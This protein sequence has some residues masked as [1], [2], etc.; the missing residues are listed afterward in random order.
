MAG[1][2]DEGSP[3]TVGRL[4][5]L[6]SGYCF[7]AVACLAVGLGVSGFTDFRN[8]ANLAVLF[9]TVGVFHL[10]MVPWARRVARFEA[11]PPGQTK[12]AWA[13]GTTPGSPGSRSWLPIVDDKVRLG[14]G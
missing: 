4:Y 7:L 14:V 6:A 2:V 3:R 9:G 8:T 1:M 12:E 13:E 10:L 11:I 5:C